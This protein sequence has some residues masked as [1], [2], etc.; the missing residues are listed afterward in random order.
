MA[1]NPKHPKKPPKDASPLVPSASATLADVARAAASCTA[2]P[3]YQDNTGTVFGEGPHD[4]SIMLVGE[5]PGDQ[6]DRQSRPFV[7][8][9][10]RVLDECLREAGIDRARVYVTNAVKHFSHHDVGKR[11]LHDKPKVSEV[12]ACRPWLISEVQHIK[13]K[14]LVAM[15]ATA[16]NAIFG[17]GFSITKSRGELRITEH[18]AKTLATFHPSALLRA[19]A[20]DKESAAAMRALFIEDLKRA[21]AAVDED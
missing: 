6:E 20:V 14:V 13:P 5:Q 15:G 21:K 12:N 16:A 17:K 1:T 3:L 19:L 7:G 2:C 11:R 10:G 8:P 18:A 9:A 4:A